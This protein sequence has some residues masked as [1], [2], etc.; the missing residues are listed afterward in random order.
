MVV[1]R[2]ELRRLVRPVDDDGHAAADAADRRREPDP[3]FLRLDDWHVFATPSFRNGQGRVVARFTAPGGRT[4]PLLEHE[5]GR[6]EPPFDL[7]EAYRNYLSERWLDASTARKLS[8]RQLA[9]FYR[10]KRLIP[11]PAQVGA[12]RALVRWQGAPRFPH[13]PLDDG[14]RRLTELYLATLLARLDRTELAFRWFWPSGFDAALV[15]SHDVESEEGIRLAVELADLEESL[16]F[17]SAFNFGAWYDVDP[18][19][20]RELTSRGFEVGL[21]G[22]VHDRSLFSSRGEFER[23]LPLLRARAQL[24]GAMGFRSPSTHRR[25]EWLAELPLRYDGTIPHSDPYEPQPGGCCSLWPFFVGDVVELPYTLPQDHTL[26]TLL[27]HRT[28]ALWIETARL[29]EERFGL[30]HCISHPDSGYLGD[31]RKRA[32]YAQFL[33]ALAERKRVWH[34]LPVE[35]AGWWRARDSADGNGRLALGRAVRDSGTA[36]ARLLPPTT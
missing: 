13:W 11:R 28:P 12:R 1:G 4:A 30:I 10:V 33:R 36:E 6:L 26:L 35:V 9:A 21:H 29:I 3:S 14:V 16:G 18:G 20:L 22:I 19:V 24:Y 8:P 25:F 5:D 17:R 7:D 34:A 15:L 31:A 2:H 23:Q 32:I 27:G